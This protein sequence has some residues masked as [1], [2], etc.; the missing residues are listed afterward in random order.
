MAEILDAFSTSASV[1]ILMV[2]GAVLA[3]STLIGATILISETF[4]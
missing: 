4:E 2:G 1:L 3:F